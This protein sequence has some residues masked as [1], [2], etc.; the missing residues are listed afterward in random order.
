[1]PSVRLWKCTFWASSSLTRSTNPFTLRP[2]R[3]SFQT[4]ATDGAT[5]KPERIVKNRRPPLPA[6][7]C[8]G[9][10]TEQTDALTSRRLDH[11]DGQNIERTRRLQSFY[12]ARDIRLQRARTIVDRSLEA[13]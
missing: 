8:A 2:S 5:L 13:L 7:G 10:R 9:Y 12:A 4:R 3:S 6:H 1:M 11:A